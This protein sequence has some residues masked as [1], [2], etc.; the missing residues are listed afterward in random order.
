MIENYKDALSKEL[1]KCAIQFRNEFNKNF[2][3][4]A[5]LGVWFA[6]NSFNDSWFRNCDEHRNSFGYGLKIK[7]ILITGRNKTE[8]GY[9]DAI[10]GQMIFE[11][12]HGEVEKENVWVYFEEGMEVKDLYEYVYE[13]SHRWLD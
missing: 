12:S 13:N 3:K 2:D 10:K 6:C 11:N 9:G 7:S 1:G 8:W 5:N 4:P